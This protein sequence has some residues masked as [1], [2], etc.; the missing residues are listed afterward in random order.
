MKAFLNPG[1]CLMPR[2]TRF[3]N[4]QRAL[5]THG[6]NTECLDFG[7]STNPFQSAAPTISNC[8]LWLL[9]KKCQAVN[10]AHCCCI[11]SMPV[12]RHWTPGS[13]SMLDSAESA[14][15]PLQVLHQM[16]CHCIICPH[17]QT[18]NSA[19]KHWLPVGASAMLSD[20]CNL[21]WAVCQLIRHSAIDSL[22][23]V[24]SLNLSSKPLN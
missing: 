18:N 23:L 4:I 11:S 24:A 20:M 6:S 19:V 16:E 2:S 17:T 13:S 7:L 22:T 10:K 14:L 3:L 5:L 12:M 21:L 1:N 15:W 8:W 9:P